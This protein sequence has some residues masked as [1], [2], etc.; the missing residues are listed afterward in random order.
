ML[1]TQ[2]RVVSVVTLTMPV[3]LLFVCLLTQMASGMEAAQLVTLLDMYF[4]QLDESAEAFGVQKIKTIGDIYMC[5]CGLN[6]NSATSDA[7]KE[8][9]VTMVEFSLR[10][11]EITRREGLQV[12]P[13]GVP[14]SLGRAAL[15]YFLAPTNFAW[16]GGWHGCGSSKE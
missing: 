15:C 8:D 5:A 16:E 1:P 14:V 4:N 12:R 2:L 11:M 10:A 3:I 9:V 13:P 7:G 6:A